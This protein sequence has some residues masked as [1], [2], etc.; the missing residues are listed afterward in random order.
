MTKGKKRFFEWVW[1]SMYQ[2]TPESPHIFPFN[3]NSL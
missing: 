2:G 3:Q 1:Q